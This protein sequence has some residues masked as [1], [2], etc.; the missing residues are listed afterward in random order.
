[1][2]EMTQ[3]P[4][5]YAELVAELGPPLGV[6]AAR[7]RWGTLV[8]AA[9]KGTATLVV[10]ESGPEAGSRW[11]AIAPLSK[12]A[13]VARCPVWPLATA[14]AQLGGLVAAATDWQD[15]TP[16][17]LTRHRRPVAAVIPAT[18]LVGLPPEGERID[19]DRLLQDGGTITLSYDPGCEGFTFEDGS[20]NEP[21]PARY[22]ATA[23]D[24]DGSPAGIGEGDTAAE[25]VLR[26]WRTPNR[27]YSAEPPFGDRQA[28]GRDTSPEPRF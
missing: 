15:G 3:P 12:V 14:R 6:E 26:L 19:V 28:A 9:E 24:P 23:T 25:A 22:I 10:L 11:A 7:T 16:Q 27:L 20:F 4:T 8:A 21:E 18:T 5:R 17:V 2:D 13:D 1:M